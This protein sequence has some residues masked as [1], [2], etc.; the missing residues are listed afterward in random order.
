MDPLD[1][2]TWSLP[3]LLADILES[4]IRLKFSWHTH[5]HVYASTY[6]Y[7]ICLVY[8]EYQKLSWGRGAE[9]AYSIIYLRYSPRPERAPKL[10]SVPLKYN[11]A[12][13]I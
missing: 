12:V 7:T 5:R 9:L 3:T 2:I 6:S 10:L 11:L 1:L 8:K 13:I 4:Y